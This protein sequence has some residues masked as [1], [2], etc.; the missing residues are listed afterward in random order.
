MV[1]DF[2]Q[3]EGV[4]YFET[5]ASITILSFWRILLAIAVINDWKIKHI[6]FIKAFLNIDLKEDIYIQILEGFKTFTAKIIKEKPKIVKLFKKL[7]YNPFKKQIILFAKTL[8]GLK[9]SSK[10]WQLKLKTLFGEHGFEPLISDFTVFYNL[11]YGIFIVT[12]IDDCLF[13][14]PRFNEINIVKRKIAK[15]YVIEDRVSAE[16]FL[17]V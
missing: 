6:D 4:D 12:F 9:Q 3:I 13:I 17:E 7:G 16:Y 14:G 10:K 5:F 11:Y 1:R 15:E 8:Y 2:I